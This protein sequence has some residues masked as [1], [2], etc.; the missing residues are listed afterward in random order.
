MERG[1]EIER[2]AER[3]MERQ[4]EGK[5]TSPIEKLKK[6]ERLGKRQ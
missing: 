3:G 2:D 5:G 1:R 6:G 4:S